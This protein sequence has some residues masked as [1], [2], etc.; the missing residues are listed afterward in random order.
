MSASYLTIGGF[1]GAGKTTAMLRLAELLVAR[2]ACASASSPT[3]RVAGLVDTATG[4]RRRLPGA[5]DHRR[6]LLL[7]LRRRWSRRPRPRRATSRPD[8]FLAEPVGSC[9]DLRATVQLPLAAPLRR[10]LSRGAAQRARVDPLRAARAFDLDSG[11]ELLRARAL[12]L[13]QAA[14]G[15]RPPRAQQDRHRRRRAARSQLEATLARRYPRA[16]VLQ[17]QRAD[18]RR[19]RGLARSPARGEPV[20]DVPIAP[21]DPTSTSTTTSTP[22]GEALL[23]WVERDAE[24]RRPRAPSTATLVLARLADALRDACSTPAAVEDRASQDVARE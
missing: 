21:C 9:T 11:P 1:L 3:I 18:R 22:T 16:E 19:G 4:G 6:L 10:R 23:G 8:V 14:R 2:A 5:R 7:P 15:S 24:R 20:S 13:R 12:H 17:R